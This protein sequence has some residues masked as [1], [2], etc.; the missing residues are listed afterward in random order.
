MNTTHSS[1]LAKKYEHV[2]QQINAHIETFNG[3]LAKE[4]K[5]G[6]IST[7]SASTYSVVISGQNWNQHWPSK[8]NAGVYILL[9]CHESD[10]TSLA[11]YIG[12]ASNSNYIGHR[13]YAHLR[14]YSDSG[15]WKFPKNESFILEA[16]LAIPTGPTK[17]RSLTTSLAAALEEHIITCGLQCVRLY[18]DI[19]IK[20]Q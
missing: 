12:K 15:I 2:I 9:A 10:A 11:A 17:E 16:V 13:L 20:K 3:L 4:Y 18:N 7:S 14:K 8:D 6:L 1:L 5:I 19:G